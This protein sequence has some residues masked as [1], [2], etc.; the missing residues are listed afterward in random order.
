MGQPPAS[1][2]ALCISSWVAWG[3]VGNAIVAPAL[4]AL[5]VSPVAVPTVVLSNHPGLGAPAGQPTGDGE[6]AA[7]LDR[8][9]DSAA[10]D[11]CRGVLTGYFVSP[12][13]VAAAA[14]AVRR[15]KQRDP[16]ILYL[17]DPVLGDDGG[18]Y[19]PDAVATAI[20]DLL[21]PLADVATPNR[22]ELSWL[23]GRD[24]TNRDAAVRAA[25]GLGC[26]ETVAT[27]VPEPGDRLGLARVTAMAA[28][29]IAWERR[30][31]VPHGT[32]DLFAALYLAG[33]IRGPGG[34]PAFALAAA[35]LKAVIDASVGADTIDIAGLVR[36]MA[37]GV[38]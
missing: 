38:R 28:E 13:Q 33:R 29:V 37:A 23:A 3:S 9:T 17:C 4:A 22:F 1:F 14:A 16:S 19:V 27:S 5:G 35:Q 32:G 2:Q 26:A 34:G 12:A 8:L 36:L 11:R 15:L 18:L 31:R 25:Q 24:V 7:M 20:R 21:L 10:L 6:L 30:D